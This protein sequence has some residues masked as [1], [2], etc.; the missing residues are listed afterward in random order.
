M[1]RSTYVYVV[2]KDWDDG[3]EVVA[4]FTVKHELV[5]WLKRNTM[6]VGYKTFWEFRVKRVRDG[7]SSENTITDMSVAELLA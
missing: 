3:H 4:A 6:Q 7:V 2:E 1:A 5:R